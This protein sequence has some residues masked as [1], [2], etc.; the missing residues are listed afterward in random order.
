MYADRSCGDGTKLI[1]YFSPGQILSRPFTSKDTHSPK[2]DLLV[3]YDELEVVSEKNNFRAMATTALLGFHAPCFTHGADVI[4]PAD[5]NDQLRRLLKSSSHFAQG[6][7]E[8]G[9]EVEVALLHS[10]LGALNSSI[11]ADRAFI[12]EVCYSCA[13]SLKSSLQQHKDTPD[14]LT[15]MRTRT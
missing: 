6:E 5:T 11:L 1:Y 3:A 13:C 7:M 10:A 4:L 2:D 12:P 8:G 9:D 14:V 15:V